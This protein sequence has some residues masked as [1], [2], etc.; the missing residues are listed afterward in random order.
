MDSNDRQ[1]ISG[2]FDRLAQVERQSPPRD[3]EAERFIAEAIAGQPGAPYYLAQTVVVQEQ[4]LNVAQ[5]RID[6]L[7]AD[8]AE[9][10]QQGQGGFLS[11][12]F[13]GST[14]PRR[15]LQDPQPL[16]QGAPGG[17]LA[18]A[19]QTAMGVAGGV[20]L[21]HAIGGLFAGEARA[22]DIPPGDGDETGDGGYADDGFGDDLDW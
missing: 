15:P 12:L 14:P 11:G 10:R 20:L 13:G 16:P 1:A 6:R 17:F 5:A 19:A 18:G 21:A 8:L 7:E 3:A 22:A 4:A 2:L 9:A